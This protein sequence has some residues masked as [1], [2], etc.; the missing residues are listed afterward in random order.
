MSDNH[1]VLSMKGVMLARMHQS[2]QTES[3]G[4]PLLSH[5]EWRPALDFLPGHLQ[6]P[7]ENLHKDTAELLVKISRLFMT[8]LQQNVS[9]M[10]VALQ[11]RGFKGCPEA[12]VEKSKDLVHDNN[13]T[14]GEWRSLEQQLKV[15]NLDFISQLFQQ[16]LTESLCEEK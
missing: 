7:K 6:L 15:A 3:A 10:N 16:A 5:C 4:V 9:K 8:Q 13:S 12:P 11:V 14:Q 1:L 2:N